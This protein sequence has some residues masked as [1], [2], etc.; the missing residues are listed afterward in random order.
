[1]ARTLAF[2]SPEPRLHALS[3][4]LLN[5]CVL[6]VQPSRGGR[7]RS[8]SPMAEPSDEPSADVVRI[9][10]GSYARY[11]AALRALDAAT[12]KQAKAVA[13]LQM[14]LDGISS[15]PPADTRAVLGA[16][17]GAAQDVF[18]E[19]WRLTQGHRDKA[20]NDSSQGD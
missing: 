6:F 13:E 8:E 2:Q 12:S 7:C 17:V 9:P 19:L 4:R 11:R 10:I 15:A 14:A 1:V 20:A 5:L 18:L 3:N 16:R